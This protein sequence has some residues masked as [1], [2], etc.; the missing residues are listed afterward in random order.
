[1]IMTPQL[2]G[3]IEAGVPGVPTNEYQSLRGEL[4][5]WCWVVRSPNRGT[6]TAVSRQRSWKLAIPGRFQTVQPPGATLKPSKQHNFAVGGM[7]GQNIGRDGRHQECSSLDARGV[8][9][10]SKLPFIVGVTGKMRT[11][12]I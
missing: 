10:N 9:E 6:E 8:D 3:D 1:V 12:N 2:A 11:H 4:R 7:W 5:P